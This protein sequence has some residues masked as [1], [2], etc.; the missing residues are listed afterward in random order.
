VIAAQA[1]SRPVALFVPGPSPAGEAGEVAVEPLLS[2]ARARGGTLQLVERGAPSLSTIEDDLFAAPAIRD[3]GTDR[4]ELA[5]HATE[6]DEVRSIAGRIRH[7]ALEHGRSFPSFLVTITPGRGPSAALFRR[8]FA[9]AGIPLSDAAGIP[10][11]RTEGGRRALLLARASGAARS[12]RADEGLDLAAPRDR[13]GDDVEAAVEGFLRAREG[14]E[15]VARFRDLHVA[16]F[17][18]EAASEVE[19]ALAAIEIV[20]GARPLRPRDFSA[21]LRATL[22]AI[23]VRDVK[24]NAVLLVGRDAARGL[25]RPVVFHAG[26]VRGAFRRPSH[27][28]P[29]LR[30]PVRRALTD[31]FAHEGRQLATT[32]ERKSERLLLARFALETATELSILSFAERDR[33]G[34]EIRN[35][36]GLLLDVARA[37]G[38]GPPGSGD[39]GRIPPLRRGVPPRTVDATDTDLSRF[40]GDAATASDLADVLR[41]P[42]ARHLPRVLRAAESR[43]AEERLGPWDGVLEDPRAREIVDRSLRDRS[44]SVSA[45]ERMAGCPFA[46]LLDMLGLSDAADDP[47]DFDPRERGSLFHDLL[48]NLFGALNEDGLLPLEPA[49]LPQVLAALDAWHR[50]ERNRLLGE[51]AVRRLHRQSTLAVLHNDAALLLAHEAHRP[52]EERT[53][54]LFFE[55]AFAAEGESPAPTFPLPSGSLPLRGRIDRVDR[56]A[57]GRLEVIDFKTGRTHAHSGK[58]RAT[59][60]KKTEIHL[61]MPLYMEALSQVLRKPVA[62]AVLYHATSD[63]DFAEIEYTADDLARDRDEIGR[64]LAHLVAR[65]RRGW[66]PCTPGSERCCFAGLARACGP[67]VAERFA[68]KQG[69]P[70]LADHVALVRGAPADSSAEDDAP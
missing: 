5:R 2:W 58:L 11:S 52:R 8:I 42:R 6:S 54:P 43:W 7:E 1:E 51:P 67:A 59:R 28:D 33:V 3:P 29:V 18:G 32:E 12:E 41:E 39:P 38:G 68:R 45:L 37:R 4:L 13:A 63:E 40:S 69:D 66:F 15:A 17:G 47:D 27:G 16:R 19:E 49:S 10:G 65:A 31:R 48:A 22:A 44:W 36:S 60:F 70:E 20:Y 14:A 21:T 26:L 46:F 61:Q 55:L 35:P 25:V 56:R 30:D 9:K 62:R 24:D 50:R 23:P 57:D 34:G 64:I 53:V